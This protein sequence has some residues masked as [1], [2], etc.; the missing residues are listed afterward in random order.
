[1]RWCINIL[2]VLTAFLC[3]RHFLVRNDQ[4]SAYQE[5]IRYYFDAIRKYHPNPYVRI[6]QDSLHSLEAQLLNECRNYQ[7][8][9]ELHL[10]LLQCNHYFDFHSSI[11][12][13]N[14]Y[15]KGTP[16]KALLAQKIMAQLPVAVINDSLFLSDRRPIL[17]IARHSAD[18]Y[19]QTSAL[20]VP[21]DFECPPASRWP[22][23]AAYIKAML[24]NFPHPEQQLI[25]YYDPAQRKTVKKSLPD[26]LEA[27]PLTRPLPLYSFH[28]YPEESIALLNYN[29]STLNLQEKKLFNDKLS[30]FF[31]SVQNLQIRHLFINVRNNGGGSD[32]NHQ[33]IFDHLSSQRTSIIIETTST[34]EAQKALL[35]AI[36]E[37]AY[38]KY[39]HPGL[40]EEQYQQELEKIPVSTGSFLQRDTLLQPYR[41]GQYD[42]NVYV[43][44]SYRTA[45]SGSSFCLCMRLWV[46][47][48]LL[49]GEPYAD[50]NPSSGNILLMQLPNTGISFRLP[51]H[52]THFLHS[53]KEEEG[54]LQ[55]DLPFTFQYAD[56]VTLGEMKKIIQQSPL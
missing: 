16:E 22:R 11:T 51:T 10:S 37:N 33:G 6:S 47:R 45:S 38:Q 3:I 13:G 20:M 21:Y 42:A 48:T 39:G 26:L 7:S 34:A 46:P 15:Q 5:D 28:Y 24:C 27:Q 36:K 50:L 19:L 53:L 1:M 55:P 54:R 25:A 2:L 9:Y 18:Y 23:Q 52:S 32:L 8:P 40:T 31:D 41:K 35:K 14:R 43:L 17:S 4:I 56:S 12:F 30:V 29:T 49:V 44:Q